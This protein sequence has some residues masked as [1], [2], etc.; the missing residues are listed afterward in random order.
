ML[1]HES[2]GQSCPQVKIETVEDMLHVKEELSHAPETHECGICKEVFDNEAKFA[3]H[4]FGHGSSALHKCTQCE[5]LFT[6]KYLLHDHEKK[7][8]HQ[9]KTS[10]SKKSL[11]WDACGKLCRR[12]ED[13]KK[14]RLIHVTAKPFICELCNKEFATKL[15]IKRHT[16]THT[17]EKPYQCG[18][19]DRKF[20]QKIHL[21]DHEMTHKGLKPY[22]CDDCGEGLT[23][24]TH[25]KTH[26]VLHRGE[27]PYPCSMCGKAFAEKRLIKRHEATHSTK[28]HFYVKYAVKV[29]AQVLS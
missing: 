11:K 22:H 14:P 26:K 24:S 16:K 2:P 13:L 17:G 28:I 6:T 19:C 27:K 8:G 25:L 7:F 29:F 20:R 1:L 15:Q 12:K 10:K 21:K 18:M 9:I 5:M 3:D 23:T 4:I